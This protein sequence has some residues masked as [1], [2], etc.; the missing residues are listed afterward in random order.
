MTEKRVMIKN[1][2]TGKYW[3]GFGKGESTSGFF[4]ERDY[5]DT[6]IEQA[7]HY[8]LNDKRESDYLNA[9]FNEKEHE[10]IEV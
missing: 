2:Q 6:T 4:E 9:N 5:E 8:D 10:L 1:R 7:T 3:Y